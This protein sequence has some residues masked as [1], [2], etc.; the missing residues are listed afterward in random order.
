M[1]DMI[2]A[3]ITVHGRVQGVYFRAF[4]IQHARQL[5]LTGWARNATEWDTVEIC[6]EG[7]QKQIEQLIE[8]LKVGPPSSR[9]DEVRTDLSEYTGS[10]SDFNIRY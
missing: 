9:V 4:T 10:Y 6:A 7:D 2:S 8:N 5:G 1:T 3:R